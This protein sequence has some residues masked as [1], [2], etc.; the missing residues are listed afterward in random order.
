MRGPDLTEMNMSLFIK[1]C[2]ANDCYWKPILNTKTKGSNDKA[3]F[4]S[5]KPGYFYWNVHSPYKYGGSGKVEMWVR[6]K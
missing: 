5:N 1:T 3:S 6:D 4:I 2:Q